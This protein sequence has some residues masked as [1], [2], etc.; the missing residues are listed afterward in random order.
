MGPLRGLLGGLSSERPPQYRS[1]KSLEGYSSRPIFLWKYEVI[2]ARPTI[3][4]SNVHRNLLSTLF[5]SV[6]YTE[7]VRN[8]TPGV[9][10][11]KST[12]ARTRSLEG[13]SSMPILGSKAGLSRG[14]RWHVHPTPIDTRC[15]LPPTPPP[16]GIYGEE[17]QS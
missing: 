17:R 6:F 5:D 1:T 10:K 9:S 8:G 3:R 4:A 11:A 2:V 14:I 16:N 13:Y 15:L 12:T 7:Y